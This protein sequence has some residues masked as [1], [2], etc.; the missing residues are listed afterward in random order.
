MMLPKKLEG[1]RA[2]PLD[3]PQPLPIGLAVRS[4]K[5]ASRAAKLFIQ[6]AVNW[7]QEQAS[8]LFT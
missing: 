4:Q 7:T 8:L 5:I 6:T 1:V 2:L 3:P